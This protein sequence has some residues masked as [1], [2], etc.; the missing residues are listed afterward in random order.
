MRNTIVRRAVV[1]AKR[2]H[3]GQRRKYT[4]EPY[5][6]HVQQVATLVRGWGADD[7][8]VTAALLHDVLE[9]TDCSYRDIADEFGKEIADIVVELTDVY[10]PE[11]YPS[12]NRK[13]RKE[14]ETQRLATIS[15]RAKLIKR[16]DIV[17]NS[18]DIRQA[19]LHVPAAA[20]FAPVYMAELETMLVALG[21]NN[22]PR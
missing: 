10:T 5:F 15:K 6:N 19:A 18:T 8:T 21:S 3:H 22:E 13:A 1:F 12:K 11:A 20:R 14:L 2:A 16:A 9:D 17:N 7:V 4:G